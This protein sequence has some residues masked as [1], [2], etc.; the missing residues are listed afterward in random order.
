[1]PGTT[2]PRDPSTWTLEDARSALQ[3]VSRVNY[4]SQGVCPTA[5]ATAVDTYAKM[6]AGYMAGDHVQNL[7]PWKGAGFDSAGNL[8]DASKASILR[9]YA[10]APEVERIVERRVNGACGSQADFS[11]VP[12][13]PEGAVEAPEPADA[14]KEAQKR[15]ADAWKRDLSEWC[16]NERW[17]SGGR[18][19]NS[20][21]GVVQHMVAQG[22]EHL[23]GAACLRVFIDPESLVDGRVP[24]AST[25]REALESIHLVAPSPNACAIYV[26]PDTK[27]ETGIFTYTDKQDRRAAEIWFRKRGRPRVPGDAASS[28]TDTKKWYTWLRVL[29]EGKTE[30]GRTEQLFVYPWGVVPIFQIEVGSLLNPSIL[31]L[32]ATLDA[33]VTG[34]SRLIT[35]HAYAQRD[36]INAKPAGRL[37]T[38]PP[39]VET[40]GPVETEVIDGVTWYVWP[41]DRALG[42]VVNNING[43]S[44][45]TGSDADGKET[46]GFTTP[47]IVYHEPSDPSVVLV[48]I[49]GIVA[50]MRDGCAQGHIPSVV[51]STAEASG[52]AYEQRRAE[53]LADIKGVA[54]AVDVG[55]AE[56]LRCVTIMA[57]WMVDE[58][59]ATAFTD[60]YRI[61]AQSHPN[62]G[63]VSADAQR[64][65]SE[66]GE[67]RVLAMA[68]VRARVGVQDVQ[69]EEDAVQAQPLTL[70]EQVETASALRDGGADAVASYVKVGMD[71]ETARALARTDGPPFVE[72]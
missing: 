6:A 55:V 28:L 40:Y 30:E 65:A 57:D 5:R 15:I 54:E 67:K 43:F 2:I 4:S 25:R 29:T 9:H 33:A 53:H 46:L 12:V 52:E 38:T 68:T 26:D 19:K 16:D 1:M 45:Q 58:A 60:R 35:S 50:L 48:G 24:D 49:G 31:S 37:S 71:E 42:G 13:E 62:A 21:R 20:Q 63:P 61:V 56:M 3:S 27:R 70:K 36:E 47:Q 10:S 23:N 17:W 34:L 51:G 32:Q 64:V 7:V 72:Q 44:Y 14:Q 69:A 11:V 18:A 41:Q 8:S 66:L 59:Q 22:T 39:P